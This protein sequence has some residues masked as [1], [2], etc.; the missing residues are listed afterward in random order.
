MKT[1]ILR[2]SLLLLVLLTF[3]SCAAVE[4][5]FKAGMG[6]GIFIVVAIIAV[7]IFIIAKLRKK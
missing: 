4:G 5:I 6:V 2:T 1:Y 3:N 7:I